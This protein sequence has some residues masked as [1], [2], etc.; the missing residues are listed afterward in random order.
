MPIRKL[1]IH[2]NLVTRDASDPR[3]G[4]RPPG[5]MPQKALEKL[6]LGSGSQGLLMP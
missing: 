3:T 5:R 2:V 1:S 4:E 6:L